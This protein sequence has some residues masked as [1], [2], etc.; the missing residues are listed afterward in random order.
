MTASTEA[1]AARDT[2]P[3]TVESAD[4]A[5]H[6]GTLGGLQLTFKER[7]AIALFIGIPFLAVLAAVPFAWGWGLGWHD[8]V[9]MIAMYYISGHGVTIGYHR[10]FTHSSFKANRP[11][12]VALAIAGSLAAEG[13]VIRWVSDH[14]KHHRYSDQDGDPHSP[15]RYGTSVPALT[16][17]LLYAHMGWL[18][19]VEQTDPRQYAPDLLKDPAI[20]KVSRSFV[21]LTVASLLIAPLIGGLWAWSWQGAVTAF[22]WGS[23]VRIG[24]L[25]HVTW[26]IN[27]ICHAA[28]ERTF[29]SR[30]KSGNVWWLAVLSMGE[31]W[32]NLHHSD[33][34]SA[35]HGVLP[36]QVDSSAR[37]IWIFEKFGWVRDVRWPTPDRIAAR[38][39]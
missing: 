19:D 26:S 33:P 8:I 25:H 18:F 21:L 5:L 35:R 23:L 17:G 30:D 29:K 9:I 39:A 13:P 16:K 14:R 3:S 31:S 6:I 2:A 32:H 4:E 1:R 12:R 27:S 37:I 36:G 22:F 24:L 38:R 15:W 10:Y 34:T 11:L 28:G 7:T 20:V